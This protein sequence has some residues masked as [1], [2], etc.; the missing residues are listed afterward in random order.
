[1][2]ELISVVIPVYKVELYIH[3]C[4]NSIL[5]QTY[6]NLE[7]ILV[8][9]GSP[10]RCGEICD[11]YEK[12]DERVKVIHKKNGGLSDARNAGIEISH[13]DY[14]TF[15][16]SDDWINDKY[17][18]KLY[19]LLKKTNSDIS[20]CN[21]IRTSTEDIKEVIS[22]KEIYE[23]S[24][25]DALRQLTDKFCI[26][27]TTAWG[28]LYKMELFEEIRF[29]VKRI[30]EDEFTTYKLIYKANKVTFST[31]CLYYYW[32]RSDSIMGSGFNLK[33]RFDYFEALDE[34]LLLYKQEQL[35][36]LWKQTIERYLNII[37]DTYWQ[38]NKCN[39]EKYELLDI[40]NKAKKL[41]DSIL[42]NDFSYI[43]RTKYLMFLKLPIITTILQKTYEKFCYLIKR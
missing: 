6:K 41:K 39:M 24:N 4:V 8:D 7:I 34:R 30:H 31:E 26:Q 35:N 28:K 33:A 40:E 27:M 1:M 38:A 19:Q 15:I 12:L 18:E 21:F 13:G 37:I 17:I 9:D 10:D 20:V 32:Q 22:E 43:F 14:I 5:R 29:P 23:Y 16:D 42:G 3:R 25:V 11:E 2:T 36:C